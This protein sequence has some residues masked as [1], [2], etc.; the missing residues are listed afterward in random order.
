MDKNKTRVIARFASIIPILESMHM[1]GDAVS[2]YRIGGLLKDA[3]VSLD[4]SGE[5]EDHI[6]DLLEQLDFA[7]G[8]GLPED[9]EEQSGG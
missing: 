1:T 7:L 4:S 8:W 9:A 2:A 6:E 5:W 3:L